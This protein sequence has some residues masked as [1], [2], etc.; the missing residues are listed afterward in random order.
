MKNSYTKPEAEVLEISKNPIVIT[1]SG[2]G[3]INFGDEEPL[4]K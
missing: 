3:D 1:A 2:D 4:G